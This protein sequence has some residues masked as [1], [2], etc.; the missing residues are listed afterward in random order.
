M[1]PDSPKAIAGEIVARLQQAGFAAF[2]VGGCVRD[3]L[4][5]REPQDFDIAT[6]AK[7]EQVE[8]LFKRTVAVG[9]K[10]GVMVVVENKQQFQV[11]TFRAEADYQDGRR[12]EKIIFANA[13]ADALRRDFTVNGLFYDP[14]TQKIHDWVGG[15]KD[16]RAK[17]IRTIGSPE[18]R[19]GEDHLRMLRAVRFAAQLNFEI[20]PQTFAAV[21]LL[22]PKIKIISA[23]RVRDE[24]LKLFAPPQ[25]ERINGL[26][27]KWI[28]GESAHGDARSTQKSNNPAI[29]QSNSPAA[30]GLVLLRDSG[31]L[32]HILPEL[33]ATIACE[34]SPDFHPEGSVFNHICLM[35]EKLPAGAS[36]SL[37][38]AVLL[39]DIAKPV[40]VERDAATGKIHFY[41]H[42]KVGAEMAEQILARLRFPNKQTEE[43]VACVRNHMQFKDVKQMRKATLR[44]LL[45]R[46][47]FPL[48]LELHRLDCLGSS[49]DLEHYHFLL[50]QAEELKHQPTI[51]PPLLTGND[52]I[53]LGIRPGRELGVLLHE[54]RE[55]QLADE[56]QTPDEAKAWVKKQIENRKSK[57]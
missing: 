50:E 46:E 2:W 38:W 12:P 3:F 40:T 28:G 11:A 4:L 31:L 22:A 55:L 33:A 1:T 30:R 7:P 56:L 23:E 36:E 21:Q 37:S 48:E 43:I 8:K 47:T 49:G 20:E 17:I 18:E 9:R 42:E 6:D 27:D 14:L 41:G 25:A 39:H 5:G 15:E 35:L 32:E 29:Q 16:L 10:F 44:R 19:F 54:I 13:E 52:L 34:Q 24:L 45:M 53:A 57:I 26:M 51:R